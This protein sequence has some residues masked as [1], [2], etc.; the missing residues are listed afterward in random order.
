MHIYIYKLC[1]YNIYILI[2]N[3]M[4]KNCFLLDLLAQKH[5]LILSINNN[6]NLIQIHTHKLTKNIYIM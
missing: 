4:F 2:I 3:I 1:I 5:P 6:V